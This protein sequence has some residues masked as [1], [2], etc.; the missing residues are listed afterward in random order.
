MVPVIALYAW[1]MVMT[2]EACKDQG[3]DK[4]G[5]VETNKG[6]VREELN[7]MFLMEDVNHQEAV[8]DAREKLEYWTMTMD[9]DK[10]A[11]K[12]KASKFDMSEL[13]TVW[14]IFVI[15]GLMFYLIFRAES[16]DS[17]PKNNQKYKV[18]VIVIEA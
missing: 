14:I 7:A 17:K 2:F 18:F 1:T 16:K 6:D 15:Y 3:K 4:V 5:T 11:K 12:K 13:F 10:E 8:A 9:D